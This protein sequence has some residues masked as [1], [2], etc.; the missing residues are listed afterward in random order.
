MKLRPHQIEKS[1]ELLKVLQKYNIAYLAGEVRS[2][3]TLTA[4][5]TAEMFGA[6]E[7]LIITKKNAIPSIIKDYNAVGF[8]YNLTGINYESLHKIAPIGYDFIIYDEAHS[9]GA[10]PKRSKRTTLAK[11]LFYNVPCIL[12]SGT[13]FAE[14]QS[15][16]YHQFFVCAFSPFKKYTNFYKWAND[17]VNKKEMRLPTHT[18]INYS[19]A[20][21]KDINAIIKPYFVKMTQQDAGL[22]TQIKEHYLIVKTPQSLVNLANKLIKDRAIEGEKG[23]ILGDLPAKLQSKVHQIVN[24]HCIIETPQG[25]NFTKVFSAYKANF[26][27]H[28]FANKKIVIMY[29]Y[30]AELDILKRTF[31]NITTDVNEF[32]DTYYNIAVQ[33]NS[34]EGMNLSKADV[35]VYFN[36]GYSGKNFIQSR[37]R[38]TVKGRE[39]NNIYFVCEDFG[40][41]KKILDSVTQKKDY[42]SRTFKK[43]FV[44]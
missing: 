35:I 7:V 2:G 1:N 20:K 29:F 26:I 39:S 21:V 19:D 30:Q 17:F 44:N 40:M 28:H 10:Y 12:M 37:D 38:L 24:G 15:Q 36:L 11:K 9:L 3:K 33:Q 41:T 22:E 18:V 13:P 25:D 34:T 31:E 5:N 8:S 16:L 4:L 14:S 23:F 27:K 6:K 32:N 42:N 43:D